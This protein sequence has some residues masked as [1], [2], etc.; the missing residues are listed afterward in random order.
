M[1]EQTSQPT[2]LGLVRR[3]MAMLKLGDQGK[4]DNFFGRIIRSS[5]QAIK[6]LRQQL[7][8]LEFNQTAALENIDD[9]IADAKTVLDEVY[10]SVN[11]DR[12]GTNADMD[13]Y[14]QEYLSAVESAEDRLED[15]HEERKNLIEAYDKKV[16]DINDQILA[17]QARIDKIKK[18]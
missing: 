18:G 9:R 10:L 5:E 17:Y 14:A 12:L 11:V 6:G 15:L 8:N 7:S 4:V 3:V 1:S 2:G 16:K 13:A